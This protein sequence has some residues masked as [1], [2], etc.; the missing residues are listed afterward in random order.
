MKE[1]AEAKERRVETLEKQT[2]WSFRRG[3]R[4]FL[5]DLTIAVLASIM[6]IFLICGLA[7]S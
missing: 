1:L 3:V 2:G 6:I 4:E 5:R 7:C